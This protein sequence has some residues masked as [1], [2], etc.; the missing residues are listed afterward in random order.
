MDTPDY[1]AKLISHMKL[2]NNISSSYEN[3]LR[4]SLAMTDVVLAL[5]LFV[6]LTT[7]SNK[8][9]FEE[10]EARADAVVEAFPSEKLQTPPPTT[11]GLACA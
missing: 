3:A 8:Q 11:G 2:I 7:V 1:A 6:A 9:R 4:E 5:D 10:I